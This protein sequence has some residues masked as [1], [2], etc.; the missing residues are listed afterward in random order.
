VGIDGKTCLLDAFG[1]PPIQI[2]ASADLVLV[3]SPQRV[4][5][6]HM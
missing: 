1:V 5:D 6:Q 3:A 4:A 2:S